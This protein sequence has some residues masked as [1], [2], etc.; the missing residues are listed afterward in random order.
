[1]AHQLVMPPLFYDDPT[2]HRYDDPVQHGGGGVQR[3]GSGG[4][5][6]G[7]SGGAAGGAVVGAMVGSSAACCEACGGEGG[8]EGVKLD[9]GGEGARRG[10]GGSGAGPS[11]PPARPLSA[12]QVLREALRGNRPR[13]PASIHPQLAAIIT[14]ATDQQPRRRPSFAQ[15]SVRLREL[16]APSTRA[17]IS[18][19][20]PPRDPTAIT[21]ERSSPNEP[22]PPQVHLSSAAPLKPDANL[23]PFDVTRL[24]S[25]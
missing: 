6:H 20:A 3:G 23:W 11:Q 21:P 9:E 8:S 10:G 18:S 24:D 15:M 7:G 2:H 17:S 19:A 5:Q 22:P 13:L 16:L 14:S 4:E 1:M 12:T 25:N